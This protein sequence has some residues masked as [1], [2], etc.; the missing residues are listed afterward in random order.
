ME[1]CIFCKIISGEIPSIRLFENDDC[2]AAMDINPA[3][4]GHA[5]IIP[6]THYR[7]LTEVPYEEIGKCFGVARY[8]G[9]RQKERL[10]ADGFNVIQNNGAVSGQ[11]VM[12][13][14]IH[15]IPRYVGGA[16]VALWKPTEPDTAK[17]KEIAEKLTEEA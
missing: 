12:H 9:E 3:T 10:G 15:V 13:F 8:I 7:D 17:L 4:P 5:L 14:H 16:Q 11:T 6:K 2:I 1:N